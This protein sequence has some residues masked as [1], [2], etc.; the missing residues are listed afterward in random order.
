[1]QKQ[2]A[3][4]TR[5]AG[6]II[7]CNK[8]NEVIDTKSKGKSAKRITLDDRANIA[9]PERKDLTRKQWLEWGMYLK[10]LRQNDYVNAHVMSLNDMRDAVRSFSVCQARCLAY[11]AGLI[12]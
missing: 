1:M 4:L 7:R 10:R 2:V 9:K 12:K 11:K 6:V 5:R 8:R 3:V